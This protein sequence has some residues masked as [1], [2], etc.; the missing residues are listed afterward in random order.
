MLLNVFVTLSS[1]LAFCTSTLLFDT[2]IGMLSM[3][4]M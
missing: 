4:A 3:I 2:L 1:Q